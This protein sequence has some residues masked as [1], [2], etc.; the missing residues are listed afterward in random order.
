MNHLIIKSMDYALP[1]NTI[2]FTNTRETVTRYRISGDETALSLM[3]DATKKAL[4]K[5]NFK[6]I[7]I[8]LI[9]VCSAVPL[10]LIPCGASIFQHH[11][12]E[13]LGEKTTIPSFDINS[14]CSSFLTALDTISYFLESGRYNR[15]LIV[16]CDTGSLALNENQP[17]SFELFSD[18]AVACIVEKTQLE[19]G[20]LSAHMVT[21]PS[22]ITATQ[23][24]GGG[25]LLPPHQYCKEN[26]EDFLFDM[27]GPKTLRITKKLVENFLPQLFEKTDLTKDDIDI[28]IPHQASL[29]LRLI[30]KHLKL[31]PTKC[32]DL[33]RD[34]G[35]MVTASVPFGLCY[36]LKNQLINEGDTV[37]LLGTAA[38]ISV[39]GIILK[40]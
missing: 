35:N 26:H 3:I 10:Q 24:K 20:I 38:G 8:D 11:L 30:V 5:E 21:D 15:I 27:N 32:L 1:Q 6:L 12:A 37:L 17:E 14:T 29:A 28:I 2:N 25:S 22:G 33:V 34:Y 40:F 36:A 39:N 18:C 16:S 7:D 19:K 4:S 13:A 23:I 9:V 31:D